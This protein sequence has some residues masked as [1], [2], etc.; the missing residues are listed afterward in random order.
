[1]ID[2][3]AII[4]RRLFLQRF[5]AGFAQ[6][7]IDTYKQ[8]DRELLRFL[9]EWEDDASDNDIRALV[10]GNRRNE[11]VKALYDT[12]A[13]FE[14]VQARRTQGFAIAQ[15]AE[16][17]QSEAAA[18]NKVLDLPRAI[19]VN[20][21]EILQEPV[22]GNGIGA[23]WKSNVNIWFGRVMSTIR[24]SAQQQQS[25]VP[26]LRGTRTQNRRD[27]LIHTRNRGI[28]RDAITHANGASNNVALFMYR[29]ARIR[30]EQFLATLDHRTC[31]LCSNAEAGSPYKI[32]TA[33]RPPLH[34]RCRCIVIPAQDEPTDRP[35]VNDDR[36]VKDIPKNE[37]AGKIGQTTVD[38]PAFFER[39]T[40][41]AKRE[42]L[43]PARYELYRSGKFKVQ[44]F[45]DADTGQIYTLQDLNALL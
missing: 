22:L 31:L 34:Q 14:K 44:D 33:P 40:A 29:K 4:L 20:P 12:V 43:G 27:G 28:E 9:R 17:I 25:A 7:M 15:M 23:A 30:Q 11:R 36:S 42:I 26:I 1:M 37:R 35:F 5:A 16:L 18:M 39:Q 32:G 10:R 19:T 6:K 45:A 3:D 21:L 8:A 2:T 24:N 41:A 38:Y 13:E